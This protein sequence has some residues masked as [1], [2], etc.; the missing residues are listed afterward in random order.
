[1]SPLALRAYQAHGRRLEPGT[2]CWIHHKKTLTRELV[3]VL[4]RYGHDPNNGIEDGYEVESASDYWQEVLTRICGFAPSEDW[5][6]STRIVSRDDL[7]PLCQDVLNELHARLLGKG[8]GP[9]H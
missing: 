7:Y 8:P 3:R 5:Q 4:R 6:R 2:L 9:R 1:M